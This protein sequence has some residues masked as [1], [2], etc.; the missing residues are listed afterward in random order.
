M[1]FSVAFVCLC[2]ITLLTAITWHKN[3]TCVF[4]AASSLMDELFLPANYKVKAV[5]AAFSRETWVYGA[6][7]LRHSRQQPGNL[8]KFSMGSDTAHCVV[9]LLFAARSELHIE[10]S[11]SILPYVCLHI[12][13]KSGA[14][15]S[16]NFSLNQDIL[17]YSETISCGCMDFAKVSFF[18]FGRW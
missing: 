7:S 1:F 6:S 11:D 12:K 2:F 14:E 13:I 4:L 16:R 10:T 17:I 8:E 15:R 5:D 3:A 9:N 18:V